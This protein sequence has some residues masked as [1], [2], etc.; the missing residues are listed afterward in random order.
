M[1]S[2]PVE[3]SHNLRGVVVRTRQIEEI[4]DEYVAIIRTGKKAV[5][6]R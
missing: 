5:N 4:V 3:F 1:D 6:K 2:L